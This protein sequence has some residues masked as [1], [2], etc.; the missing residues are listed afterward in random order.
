MHDIVTIFFRLEVSS[1]VNKVSEFYHNLLL[2]FTVR[3]IAMA[4]L[5]KMFHLK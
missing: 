4:K 5:I 1:R 2:N 3:R